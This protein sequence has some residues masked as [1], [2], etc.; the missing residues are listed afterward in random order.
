MEFLN[1][2]KEERKLG[3]GGFGVVTLRKNPKTNN[4]IACKELIGSKKSHYWQ[5]EVFILNYIRHRNIISIYD[6]IMWGDFY[7]IFMEYVE[8][9]LDYYMYRYLNNHERISRYYIA[10]ISVSISSALKY[11]HNKSLIH[12]DVKPAN[13]VLDRKFVKIKLIDFGVSCFN[14]SNCCNAK[15]VGTLFYRSPE[16]LLGTAYAYEVDTWALGCVIAEMYLKRPL[17]L[18]LPANV[19]G[20]ISDMIAKIGTPTKKDGFFYDYIICSDRNILKKPLF[21]EKY[22]FPFNDKYL[23]INLFKW[24]YKERV[25]LIDIYQYFSNSLHNLATNR[26]IKNKTNL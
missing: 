24:N 23:L 8:M 10:K 3:S 1:E 14:L 20:Q 26:I 7:Y 17:F 4:L 12:R 5:K 13:I 19:N 15:N 11:C 16:I 2:Y 21:P 25:Q 22:I 6:S 9:D 18:S